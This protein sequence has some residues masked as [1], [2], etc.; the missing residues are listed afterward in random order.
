MRLNARVIFHA[1]Y[2]WRLRQEVLLTFVIVGPSPLSSQSN[3]AM[4][5]IAIR[6]SY[7]KTFK[8]MNPNPVTVSALLHP[9]FVSISPVCTSQTQ[10]L[11]EE[12]ERER[13]RE[14][15]RKRKKRE[16]KTEKRARAQ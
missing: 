6:R 11:F 9:L 12:G 10:L 2:R 8:I 1:A 4:G 5:M 7:F 13:E 16:K 15:K 14:R 3:I